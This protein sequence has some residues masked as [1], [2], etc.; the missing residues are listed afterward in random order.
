M[1]RNFSWY[2]TKWSQTSC[3]TKFDRPRETAEQVA[4]QS[5][6]GLVK[7]PNKLLN[8][9]WSASWSSRT[10]LIGKMMLPNK[11]DLHPRCSMKCFKEKSSWSS[12]GRA[13]RAV[14]E[15]C[16]SWSALAEQIRAVAEKTDQVAEQTP[17]C[18][19]FPKK[20]CFSRTSFCQTNFAEQIFTEQMFTEQVC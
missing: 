4:E 5:L 16:T 6:I 7:H 11:T 3:W 14:A 1:P 2:R 17:K 10:S 20:C 8:K 19:L 12:C 13:D 15:L 9:V 18:C